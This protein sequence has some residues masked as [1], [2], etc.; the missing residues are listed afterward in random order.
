ME[1]LDQIKQ[2]A[3]LPPGP[4]TLRGLLGGR[5]EGLM[6]YNQNQATIDKFQKGKE[7]HLERQKF[8][9]EVIDPFQAEKERYLRKPEMR[10][11]RD[12]ATIKSM[13]AS[14]FSTNTQR[15]LEELIQKAKSKGLN[16]HFIGAKPG[17]KDSTRT[18]DRQADL[19]KTGRKPTKGKE[20]EFGYTDKGSVDKDPDADATVTDAL[21]GQSLHNYPGLAIDFA[22]DPDTTKDQMY[23]EGK[24]AKKGDNEFGF[25]V[26]DFNTIGK[27]AKEV[28]FYWGGDFKKWN[29]K[30][31]EYEPKPDLPHL[32]TIEPWRWSKYLGKVP[33]SKEIESYYTKDDSSPYGFQ[34]QLHG[35]LGMMGQDNPSLW[36]MPKEDVTK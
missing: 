3:G 12:Y 17:S 20:D 2:G 16:V 21:A 35:P 6:D 15:M 33:N 14:D 36:R 24:W 5:K 1:L 8:R 34:G 13:G 30:K 9:E 22:F 7:Y 31:K 32:Q 28:G 27:L 26:E 11:R 4:I 18:M 25:S 23:R 19:F 29:P 10:E